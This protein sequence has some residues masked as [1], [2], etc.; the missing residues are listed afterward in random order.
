MIIVAGYLLIDPSHRDDAIAAIALGV[1]AT[2]A[3][4][5]NLDYRFSP[6]LDDPN[7]FNLIERWES[8]EA[9]NSHMAT[10]H[11]AEFMTAIGPCLGGAPEVIRYDVS[12][13]SP[14]F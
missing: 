5:G 8:E 10:S 9:M 4:P 7:R 13:S 6:D 1:A 14:L 3:E 11:L 12:G 2:R